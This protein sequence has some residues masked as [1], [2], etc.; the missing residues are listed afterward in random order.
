LRVQLYDLNHCLGTFFG[1]LFVCESSLTSFS[2]QK[3]VTQINH[4]IGAEGYVSYECKNII[5]NYFD[6]IWEYIISGVCSLYLSHY[7]Q[8]LSKAPVEFNYFYMSSVKA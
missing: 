4:A 8:R 5:H 7:S 6:S 3:I 2:L 1:S